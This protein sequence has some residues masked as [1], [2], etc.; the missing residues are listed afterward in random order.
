MRRGRTQGQEERRGRSGGRGRATR[1]GSRARADDGCRPFPRSAGSPSAPSSALLALSSATPGECA[2]TIETGVHCSALIRIRS[3]RSFRRAVPLRSLSLLCSQCSG[4]GTFT[5]LLPCLTRLRSSSSTRQES[6]SQAPS[7]S[8]AHPP[9]RRSL[10]NFD[11]EWGSLAFGG[12]VGLEAW[13][14]VR[15]HGSALGARLPRTAHAVY[16][17]ARTCTH[18]QCGWSQL[19]QQMRWI[20][21]CD[22][23]CKKNLFFKSNF[24]TI[25]INKSSTYS[26]RVRAG[27]AEERRMHV[28]L[29]S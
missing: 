7:R 13:R 18:A 27:H 15:R 21:K 12:C 26:V 10:S 14:T 29:C 11:F 9:S 28:D 19:C 6:Q 25:D 22:T 24:R 4:R 1:V 20:R 16:I 3:V 17:S 23:V 2:R 8:T 5:P